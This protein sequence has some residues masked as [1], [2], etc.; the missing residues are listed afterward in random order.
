MI[1]CS[2][3]AFN[4]AAN[5]APP[6]VI[7]SPLP[8]R[9]P[10]VR[11]SQP[12]QQIGVVDLHPGS[13]LETTDAPRRLRGDLQERTAI[14]DRSGSRGGNSD[15][16]NIIVESTELVRRLDDIQ[17]GIGQGPRISAAAEGRT[18]RS[19]SL[20]GDRRWPR[21]GPRAGR[22]GVHS[23]LSVPLRTPG[24]VLGAMNVYAHA[25]DALDDHAEEV[26][27]MF[28]VPAAIS[29]LK[30][31][32]LAQ[33]QRVA[34]QLD[35]ALQSRAIIDRAI[36]ILRSRH[37]N[38]AQEAFDTHSGSSANPGTSISSRWP[39]KSSRRRRPKRAPA[40]PTPTHLKPRQRS[41]TT[42]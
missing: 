7:H 30:A 9:Q 3:A 36:G 20:G 40:V 32:I 23:V 1:D 8:L 12:P 10:P 31:Q 35:A 16:L 19:G 15:R 38:T 37:G 22:L 42:S 25:H 21:F 5:S 28:M 6:L 41:R 17:Y 33:S 13:L 14:A 29:V 18:M 11:R 4:T 39:G 27:E 24:G 26:G 34:T 2:V